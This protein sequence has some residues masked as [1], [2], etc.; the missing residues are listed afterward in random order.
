VRHFTPKLRLFSI[1]PRSAMVN[2]ST[3]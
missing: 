2:F 3:V 1:Y